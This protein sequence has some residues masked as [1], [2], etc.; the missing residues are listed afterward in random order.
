MSAELKYVIR[1]LTEGDER[2]LWQMLY[3]AIYVPEGQPLPEPDVVHRPELARYVRD[4]GQADDRGFIAI[5]AKGKEAIGAAWLRLLRGDNKGF[6][7]VDDATPELSVALVPEYRGQ[8]L[9]TRLLGKLLQAASQHY[10]AVSLSVAADNPALRWYQRLGFD[11][12]STSGTSLTMK[13]TLGPD[14]D[15]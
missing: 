3:H 11:V 10:A 12:V 14:D 7:Y 5:D 8:G 6:G 1:P 9:G 4:W 13:K 15:V 2:F